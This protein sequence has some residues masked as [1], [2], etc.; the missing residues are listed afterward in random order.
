MSAPDLKSCVSLGYGCDL[1][2]ES[3]IT[4]GAADVASDLFAQGFG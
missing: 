2:I 1:S 4:L 3:K